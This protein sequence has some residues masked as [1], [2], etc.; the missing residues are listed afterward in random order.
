MSDDVSE[1]AEKI[2][3]PNLDGGDEAVATGGEEYPRLEETVESVEPTSG[4]GGQSITD[5][6]MSTE[7]NTPL[8]QVESPW[9][10]EN[11][12]IPRIW[13]GVQKLTGGDVQGMPAIMDII[14]GMA[15]YA[16]QNEISLDGVGGEEEVEAAGWGD[17]K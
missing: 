2:S 3:V 1:A 8:E 10:T 6:L 17:P 16:E 7:P 9:D 15:E 12:G 5:R 14:I 4:G 13:R 11:G